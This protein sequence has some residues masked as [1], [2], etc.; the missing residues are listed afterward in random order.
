MFGISSESLTTKVETMQTHLNHFRTLALVLPSLVLGALGGIVLDRQALVASAQQPTPTVNQAV[1]TRLI[2]EAWDLINRSYVDRSVVQPQQLTYAAIRGMAEALGDT[3]H[4]RFLTP[5]AVQ[6]R[7]N[8]MH[9]VSDGIGISVENQGGRTVILAALDGSP[10]Q[11]AGL[12]PGDIILSVDGVKVDGLAASQISRRL[13]GPAGTS[14][15]LTIRDAKTGS[16]RGLTVARARITLHN[17]TWALIPGTSIAEIRVAHF[18]QGVA[19]DLQ[20]ALVQVQAQ[21][22]TGII[23]DL[24]NDPG[25]SLNE[26]IGV[27]S[28][29]LSSGNV[30]EEK[31]AQGVT[32]VIPVRPGG[33]AT[34]LPLV[35]LINR[36]TASASEIVAS[37][38]QEARRAQL[39][40]VTTFGTGTVLRRFGLSDGSA[41]LLATREWRTPSG[42]SFWHKGIVPDV[43]VA[44]PASA[45]PIIPE[46]LTE[47]SSAELRA[48]A[49]LQLFKGLELLGQPL[50][51]PP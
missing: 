28:Q 14:V 51:Q 32:T 50:P 39:A 4:T 6:E 37:A 18:S 35:V 47:M 15:R 11:L 19:Q 30:L 29:F 49:D 48:S 23:L 12:K 9:G 40:G 5:E 7:I 46:A 10:A 13:L 20:A 16:S 43:P 36:G 26:A 45:L 8:S 24:R 33:V 38:L 1:D 31:D 42:Q 41:L 2:S 44:E 22:A 3:G 34:D 25:G 21:G 27:A 17:V